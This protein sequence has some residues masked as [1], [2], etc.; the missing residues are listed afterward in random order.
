MKNWWCSG[1]GGMLEFTIYRVWVCTSA[2]RQIGS[3]HVGMLEFTIHRVRGL[4]RGHQHDK[5]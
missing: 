3:T 2:R 1:R 4:A 5:S